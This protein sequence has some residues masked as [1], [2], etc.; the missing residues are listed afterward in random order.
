[1]SETYYVK[2][3]DRSKKVQELFDRIAARYDFINDIQSFGLHRF[4]KAEL[5]R[6]A[7]V[8]RNQTALDLCTG[9]GDLAIKLAS[10]GARVTGCDFSEGMLSKAR[11]RS[12][13]VNWVQGDALDLSFSD[14]AFDLITIGYGLRNLAD[15]RKGLEEMLRVLKPGGRL[16]ILEFGKPAN[17]IWRE[18]YF[19]YLRMLVPMFGAVFCRDRSAYSY[20]LESLKAYPGQIG[21]QRMLEEFDCRNVRVRNFLGGVMSINYAE[22]ARSSG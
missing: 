15:F 20:I 18:I 3:P 7:E 17:A 5:I 10:Q 19:L 12:Q 22:K 6:M 11:K 14:N 4:W 8:Q 1:M 16:L 21:I 13:A 9:T 2:G